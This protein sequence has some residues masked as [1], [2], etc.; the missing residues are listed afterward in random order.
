MQLARF[1]YRWLCHSL[2]SALIGGGLCLVPVPAHAQSIDL[3]VDKTGPATVAQGDTIV[4]TVSVRNLGSTATGARISDT[5]PTGL[6]FIP[7]QST[8]NCSVTGNSVSCL[9]LGTLQGSGS[10]TITATLAFGT[11][12]TTCNQTVTNTAAAPIY[13]NETAAGNNSD[14]VT[15]TI[16]CGCITVS[17]IARNQL[18]GNITPV[19]TFTFFLDGNVQSVQN[20]GSGIATF[21]NVRVGTHTVT[22]N[23]LSGYRQVSVS[24]NNGQVVVPAGNNCATV[25]FVNQRT[26]DID[27]DDDFVIEDD[28]DTIV[29]DDDSG[30]EDDDDS[31]EDDD[32]SDND[33]DDD[34]FNEDDDGTSDIDLTVTDS[35]DPVELACNDKIL[36]R[37]NIRND[38]NSDATFDVVG[39]LDSD[40]RF[41][42]ATDNGD[43]TDRDRIRVLWD[44]L[45]VDEDTRETLAL[46]VRVGNDVPDGGS[47]RFEVDL[48]RRDTGD[49]DDESDTIEEEVEV[50]RIINRSSCNPTVIDDDEDVTPIVDDDDDRIVVP[51]IDDDDNF[52]GITG[53][54]TG[55]TNG[56]V[57]VFGSVELTKRASRPEARP[58]DTL[59]YTISVRNNTSD[60]LSNV[61]VVDS[62]NPAELRIVNAD[63]AL[64]GSNSLEWSIP[65]MSVGDQ[66]TMTYQAQV[67]PG[68]AHGRNVHNTVQVFSSNATISGISTNT[69]RIISQLPVT[70][71][72]GFTGNQ[73]TS[74]ALK[75]LT[76]N[77]T[78]SNNAPHGLWV[79]SLMGL[80]LVGSGG[81]IGLN[82]WWL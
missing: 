48:K 18:G 69:L 68:V 62:F 44:D 11:E 71:L 52:I 80:T 64:L 7:S 78:Q 76:P 3:V 53:G 56:A 4:Y 26:N 5:I 17:K 72:S 49:D 58:G 63:G 40:T 39:H 14:N 15:T 70:G 61:V 60:I 8:S 13:S 1:W 74:Y 25:T 30:D 65:F 33:E 20:N 16:Q 23:V 51:V 19:P 55:G 75:P 54:T 29:D 47:V 57:P 34:F 77:A 41:L 12:N 35:P 27:D 59:N 81:V 37:I 24:P 31:D 22:E 32:D 28:D 67:Q 6:T 82:K 50:T 43:T 46:E 21:S 38:S 9:N 10:N 36:Y 2:Q 66:R 42:A 73:E 79:L 45:D